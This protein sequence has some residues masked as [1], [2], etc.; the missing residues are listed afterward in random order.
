MI[1]EYLSVLTDPAHL[2]A[3]LTF[4]LVEVALFRPLFKLWLRKHDRE[5]HGV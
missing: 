1:H 2:A 4:V 3:E 5:V